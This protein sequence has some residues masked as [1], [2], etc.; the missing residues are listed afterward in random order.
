[1]QFS[2][3]TGRLYR[4]IHESGQADDGAPYIAMGLVAQRYAHLAFLRDFLLFR[5]STVRL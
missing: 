1:M 4:P 3:L 5:I 2:E